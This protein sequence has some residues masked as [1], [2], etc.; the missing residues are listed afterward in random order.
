[1]A[2]VVVAGSVE[3]CCGEG[4]REEEK[5]ISSSYSHQKGVG[6]SVVGLVRPVTVS[7]AS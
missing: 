5:T 1:V 7:G 6:K 2:V 4:R 3:G